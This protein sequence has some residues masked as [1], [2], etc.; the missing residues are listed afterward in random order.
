MSIRES[1]KRCFAVAIICGKSEHCIN[2]MHVSA[3]QPVENK[4][5]V[6]FCVWLA[7][8][9]SV[10]EVSLTTYTWQYIH[11]M[12]C[13]TTIRSH[14]DVLFSVCDVIQLTHTL[15]CYLVPAL[16]CTTPLVHVTE[17]AITSSAATHM[18]NIHMCQKHDAG[19]DTW[20]TP[21]T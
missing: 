18:L 10:A 2:D 15:T 16:S 12:C 19:I 5:N 3:H 11:M 13:A 6:M 7:Y 9:A 14:C 4:L 21:S 17:N 1:Y 20:Y 8:W